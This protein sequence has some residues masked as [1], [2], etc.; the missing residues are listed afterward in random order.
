MRTTGRAAAGLLAASLLA[1]CSTHTDRWTASPTTAAGGSPPAAADL[2]ASTT[3]DG[4]RFA[5]PSATSSQALTGGSST[6]PPPTSASEGVPPAALPT[7]FLPVDKTLQDPDLGHQVKVLRLAPD[8]PWPPAQAEEGR[9][10][11]LVGVEMTWTPGTTYTATLRAVDFSLGTSSAYPNRPDA[12][13]NTSLS[14]A[15]WSL[16]PAELATG[17]TATGW[18]V[19]RVEPKRSPT[20]RLDYTRPA[21]RVTDS[22]QVFPKAVFSTQLLG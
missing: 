18:L 3:G 13:L 8:L 6:S 5:D 12:I 21:S 10:L 17:Q 4:P 11:E 14:A 22:G 15:G 7:A 20:L 19:F 9:A 16:L 1:A 2:S